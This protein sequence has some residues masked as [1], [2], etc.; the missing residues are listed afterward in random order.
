M[1]FGGRLA[2]RAP[3]RSERVVGRYSRC[4]QRQYHEEH[5]YGERDHRAA[6]PCQATERAAAWRDLAR[7]WG[8]ARRGSSRDA[9][10]S[11][12]RGLTMVY[13]MSARRLGVVAGV[14]ADSTTALTTQEASVDTAVS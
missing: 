13:A 1:H 7:D 6:P 14:A 8:G 4:E 9:W 12:Q 11:R 3:A 2:H 10:G 5:D